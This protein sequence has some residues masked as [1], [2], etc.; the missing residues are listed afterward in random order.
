MQCGPPCETVC[1]ASH[2]CMKVWPSAAL[3]HCI[4]A[5]GTADW[6]SSGNNIQYQHTCSPAYPTVIHPH[7]GLRAAEDKTILQIL[8]FSMSRQL[9]RRWLGLQIGNQSGRWQLQ[10]SLLHTGPSSALGLTVPPP[11][12]PIPSDK[13]PGPRP[14]RLTEH[15][16]FHKYVCG[17]TQPCGGARAGNRPSTRIPAHSAKTSLT[18]LDCPRTKTYT[19]QTFS[20]QKISLPFY[21]GEISNF[22]VMMV[23]C[24][25]QCCSP[26]LSALASQLISPVRPGSPA[27]LHQLHRAP[28][29]RAQ[30]LS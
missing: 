30:Q 26:N 20:L 1:V 11:L 28:A 27:A 25:V 19:H 12:N 18:S 23:H 3:Q 14:P 17:K 7:P 22:S 4:A 2:C 8:S 9:Q 13:P 5:D 10:S 15:Q 29:Q 21:I 6:I 16:Q 24:T